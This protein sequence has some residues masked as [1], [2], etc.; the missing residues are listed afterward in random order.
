[1]ANRS[2]SNLTGLE[3]C[4]TITGEPQLYV[5][6]ILTS[7]AGLDADTTASNRVRSFRRFVTCCLNFL[8]ARRNLAPANHNDPAFFTERS[9]TSPTSSSV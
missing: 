6:D 3:L 2:L 8:N 5:R 9:A 4:D 7:S 1:M